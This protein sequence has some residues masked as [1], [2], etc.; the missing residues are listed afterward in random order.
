V[1]Y[2][3]KLEDKNENGINKIISTAKVVVNGFKNN[4]KLSNESY[5]LSLHEQSIILYLLYLGFS[6]MVKS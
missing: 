2:I 1:S 5:Y 6:P 4:K 3:F